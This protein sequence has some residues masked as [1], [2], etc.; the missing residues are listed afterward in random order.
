MENIAHVWEY[1]CGCA[2][3]GASFSEC[4]PLWLFAAIGAF[5]A[6]AAVALRVLLPRSERV[7]PERLPD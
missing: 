6:L 5:V 7:L 3:G 1:V 2:A 4:A